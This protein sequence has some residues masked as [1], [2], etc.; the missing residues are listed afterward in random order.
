MPLICTEFQEIPHFGSGVTPLFPV[1]HTNPAANP[2]INPRNRTIVL[3]N[4]KVIYPPPNILAELHHPVIHGYSPTSTGEF[5][6]TPLKL[7]KRFIGP[8]DFTV[9]KGKAE[10]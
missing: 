7:Q 1:A 9:F 8:T 3:C 10:K 6:D 5:P 4:S 2:L